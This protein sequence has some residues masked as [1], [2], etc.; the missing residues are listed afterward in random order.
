MPIEHGPDA[1]AGIRQRKPGRRYSAFMAWTVPY[2]FDEFY[3]NINLPGE[4]RTLA[5]TRKDWILRRIGTSLEILDSFPMGSIPRFTALKDH[6]DLDVMIVLHYG[7]HIKDKKPSSVLSQ[8]KSALGA[9]AGSVRRNGQAVTMKF[10][11]WPDVDVVPASRVTSEDGNLSHYIIPDMNR[12]QWIQTKP[13]LHSRR[14]IDA[15]SERGA[16][17]RRI[18]KM[19]KYWNQRQEVSIQSYHLE[20]IALEMSIGDWPDT[21]WAVYNWFKKA[22]NSLDWLW[23]DGKD[24]TEYLSFERAQKAKNQITGAK[25][26]ALT[27]WYHTS[28]GHSDHRE[29]IRVWRSL[30]GTNFP[31]YG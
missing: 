24:V 12:E 20:V 27:A 3:S 9:G 28:S 11:S 17:F 2:A 14:M 31:S 8:V 15:S 21:G 26:K 18:V 6:A 5:N 23:H 1:R 10:A 29:A 13:N 22:E 25:N 4:H 7:K 16:N 19:A 30:F